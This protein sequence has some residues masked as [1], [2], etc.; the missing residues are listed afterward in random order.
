MLEVIVALGM[1]TDPNELSEQPEE[2]VTIIVTGKVPEVLYECEGL[3][4]VEVV[5][6]PNLQV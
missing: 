2:L 1:S 5:P 4:V 3:A 6:S